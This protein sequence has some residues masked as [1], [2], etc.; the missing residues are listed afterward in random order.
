GVNW[1]ASRLDQ[2]TFV[3]DRRST[4]PRGP[5]VRG[6]RARRRSAASPSPLRRPYRAHGDF[7]ARVDQDGGARS[8][9]GLDQPPGDVQS[10]GHGVG[11]ADGQEPV[12]GGEDPLV[13][14][15]AAAGV[16]EV[17]VDS[18]AHVVALDDLRARVAELLQGVQE[19]DR[20]HAA[21]GVVDH[22]LDAG[23]LGGQG[24]GEQ[25]VGGGALAGLLQ[26]GPAL[27][28]AF[29]LRLGVLQL[30]DVAPQP[31][32]ALAQIGQDPD[33]LVLPGGGERGVPVERPD[34]D[35]DG[36]AEQEAQQTH[37]ELPAPASRS[38]QR[39]EPPQARGLLPGPVAVRAGGPVPALVQ[40]P[41]PV[42]VL[43]GAHAPNSFRR[44]PATLAKIRMPRTT[45]TPVDSWEPTPSWSP[46]STIS[47]AMTV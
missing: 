18:G 1:T 36:E 37:G 6:A 10:G 44:M 15:D 26:G 25:A 5:P 2:T 14:H 12:R 32:G 21:A 11:V 34:L 16:D 45:T 20:P 47:A 24:A 42:R 35:D 33:E 22:H 27:G 46:R 31:L 3:N 29:Q 39:E 40:G 28:V 38:Q 9:N 30:A 13:A 7:R 17:G 19:V 43:G 23:A 4:P 8:L 41:V